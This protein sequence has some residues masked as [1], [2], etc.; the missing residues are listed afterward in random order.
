MIYYVIVVR[1]FIV[2]VTPGLRRR[3]TDVLRRN[4][5]P[6]A[7]STGLAGNVF[8]WKRKSLQSSMNHLPTADVF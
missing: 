6:V 5:K 2:R 3:I 4:W 7:R 8:K 1:R